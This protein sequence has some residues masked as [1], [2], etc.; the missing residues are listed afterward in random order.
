MDDLR[1][2]SNVLDTRSRLTFAGADRFGRRDRFGNRRARP[3]DGDRRP[4]GALPNP[5]PRT[6]DVPTRRANNPSCGHRW[7]HG[8]TGRRHA[9]ARRALRLHRDRR[10]C[11]RHRRSLRL[12]LNRCCGSRLPS[13]KKQQRIEV[14][15]RI[16]GQ[17]NTEMDIRLGPLRLSAGADRS[18]DLSFVH[19]RADPNR[20]RA[21]VDE[22]DRIA[23]LGADREAEAL[24][25]QL[26]GETD[27][28]AGGRADLR[29]GR[30]ADVD[31]AMLTSRIGVV[32]G[33]EWSKHGP[34]H[35]PAPRGR[36]RSEHERGK[37]RD[38]NSVA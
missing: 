6:R 3:T 13:G 1:T 15:V 31:T 14:P 30:K 7:P 26:P 36:S 35:R 16:R 29:P 37:H 11:R 23:V 2:G 12:D 17:A 38:D 5:Q 20:D 33:D 10:R 34:F 22:R 9:R 28:S 21:E 4:D 32:V 18:H 24:A 27:D 8:P 25:R 19:G